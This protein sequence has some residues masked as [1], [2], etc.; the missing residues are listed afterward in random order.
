MNRAESTK[1]ILNETD[2]LRNIKETYPRQSLIS[3]I[4][5]SKRNAYVFYNERAPG[6]YGSS[7][8]YCAFPSKK[9][10]IIK[11]VELIHFRVYEIEWWV[12]DLE[13]LMALDTIP[14]FIYFMASI[15][16]SAVLSRRVFNHT[17]QIKELNIGNELEQV[18]LILSKPIARTE[19]CWVLINGWFGGMQVVVIEYVALTFERTGDEA[20]YRYLKWTIHEDQINVQGLAYQ[21]E[22]RRDVGYEDE[23]E[24]VAEYGDE[25][26][27]MTERIAALDPSRPTQTPIEES[28]AEDDEFRAYTINRMHRKHD[29]SLELR[30]SVYDDSRIPS[31]SDIPISAKSPLKQLALI[32][33][34]LK[35]IMNT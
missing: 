35:I 2:M 3:Q 10:P 16:Q 11:M 19:L 9:K 31:V 12:K 20:L 17:F 5:R 34:K 8:V 24:Q 25:E 1:V 26:E 29:V 22:E 30:L 27:Q 7:Y 18:L 13:S 14:Q 15:G 32:N 28:N 23:E 4:K 33:K 21:I 6:T